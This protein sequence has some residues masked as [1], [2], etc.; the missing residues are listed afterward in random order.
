MTR[1]RAIHTYIILSVGQIAVC[2]V[3]L[4]VYWTLF[5]VS[6][7]MDGFIC[8]VDNAIVCAF[9]LAI[10]FVVLMLGRMVK[11]LKHKAE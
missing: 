4:L 8:L 11:C 10:P 5:Q 6:F 1:L 3:F 9:F 7:D 2:F